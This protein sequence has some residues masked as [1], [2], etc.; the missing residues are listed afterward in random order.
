MIWIVP[1]PLEDQVHFGG[2][3]YV[4]IPAADARTAVALLADRF[5]HPNPEDFSYRVESGYVPVVREEDA[6]SVARRGA[7][8]AADLGDELAS[9]L[10]ERSYNYYFGL[11]SRGLSREEEDTG[12]DPELQQFF[13]EGYA[14]DEALRGLLALAPSVT[15]AELRPAYEIAQVIHPD[16][17]ETF[18]QTIDY[19]VYFWL[20]ENPQV[21]ATSPDFSL[22]S[23]TEL[24][25]AIKDLIQVG[26]IRQRTEI[27]ERT[28]EQMLSDQSDEALSA[29]DYDSRRADLLKLE[30]DLKESH[31]NDTWFNAGLEIAFMPSLYRDTPVAKRPLLDMSEYVYYKLHFIAGMVDAFPQI[32]AAEIRDYLDN[33]YDELFEQWRSGINSGAISEDVYT[34]DIWIGEQITPGLSERMD[35]L[36]DVQLNRTGLIY[37]DPILDKKISEFFNG[38][39]NVDWKLS[40]GGELKRYFHNKW[41]S[42]GNRDAFPSKRDFWDTLAPDVIRNWANNALVFQL[43]S[44]YGESGQALLAELDARGETLLSLWEGLVVGRKYDEFSGPD[45]FWSDLEN[46]SRAASDLTSLIGEAKPET[47]GMASLITQHTSELRDGLPTYLN[48]AFLLMASDILGTIVAGLGEPLTELNADELWSQITDSQLETGE[49]VFSPDLL[50]DEMI[51]SFIESAP[52]REDG[53]DNTQAII[54]SLRSGEG[55]LAEFKKLWKESGGPAMTA[56]GFYGILENITPEDLYPAAA[57][58]AIDEFEGLPEIY[59]HL[60]PFVG[61]LPPG[62]KM[63]AIRWAK[64]FFEYE[65]AT[66]GL[67]PVD[68]GITLPDTPE[69][70]RRLDRDEFAESREFRDRLEDVIEQRVIEQFRDPFTRLLIEVAGGVKGFFEEFSDF[71]TFDPA[72]IDKEIRDVIFN[73]NELPDYQ[74][75]VGVK[76]FIDEVL[77]DKSQFRNAYEHLLE[78]APETV[79]KKQEQEQL[80]LEKELEAEELVDEEERLRRQ[81]ADIQAA[82]KQAARRQFGERF[83]DV[84]GAVVGPGLARSISQDQEESLRRQFVEDFEGAYGDFSGFVSAED[85]TRLT[86]GEEF[87]AQDMRFG[88]DRIDLMK[89]YATE[90]QATFFQQFDADR[91]LRLARESQLADM[92]FDAPIARRQQRRLFRNPRMPRVPAGF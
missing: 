31:K 18:E 63:D 39:A 19:L 21:D 35:E 87:P 10:L 4:S 69:D 83:G 15:P 38:I 74:L 88:Q 9:E 47:V 64:E 36:A 54:E 13:G 82:G 46:Y 92:R 12:R 70:D 34:S 20:Q 37:E 66:Q 11:I 60:Q 67:G 77:R 27:F 58:D 40:L 5:F 71:A 6:S 81:A 51:I 14:S 90:A 26:V 3:D 84:I 16:F 17:N 80:E 57:E 25:D 55:V 59:E 32:G 50:M 73:P 2:R 30:L 78:Q 79:T 75:N 44:D 76:R 86:G 72:T 41:N 65:W 56:G 89:Q 23:F 48:T 91:V 42:D 85:F 52:P 68:E 61:H 43:A 24:E 49:M 62:L 8:T 28:Q 7:V 1:I 22:D 53:V 45:V 33:N 29:E